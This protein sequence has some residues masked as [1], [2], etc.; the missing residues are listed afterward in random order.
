MKR[1]LLHNLT[2]LFKLLPP[3]TWHALFNR[4]LGF[5]AEQEPRS[6]MRSLL[7]CEDD[8]MEH[9]NRVALRYGAGVHVKHHLTHYHD[10]FV[11]RIGSGE[12]V[13]DIGCGY[14]AVAFSIA[15]RSGAH[16]TGIDI[17]PQNIAQA[18]RTHQHP[19]LTFI[20][21]DVLHTLPPGPFETMVFSNVMEHLEERVAFLRTVQEHLAPRRWLIRVPMVNR[22]WM[23]PMRQELG[24]PHYSDPTHYTEYT[25]ESFEQEVQAAG[26]HITHLQINWGEIW[27]EVQR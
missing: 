19:N 7:Q 14:G 22:H 1:L 13:L 12:R 3:R 27:A 2:L 23:V 11:E 9:I 26:M 24:M 8:L 16:V 6:A 15:T 25:R 21:G 5:V 17:N 4:W 18:R 20:C 10:F